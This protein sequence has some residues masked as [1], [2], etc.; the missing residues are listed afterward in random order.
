MN[1]IDGKIAV[2]TGGTQGLGAAIARLFAAAGAAGIAI[3]GRGAEKGKAVAEAITAETG[4]PVM[5]ISADLGNIDDVRRIIASAD[6]RF[7]R[8]DIRSMGHA[9]GLRP[10]PP[11]SDIGTR[12]SP[13]S[14]FPLPQIRRMTRATRSGCETTPTR[15]RPI[16]RSAAMSTS[17]TTMMAVGY[18]RIMVAITID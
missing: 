6:K 2:V 14:L 5:M 13:W 8:V 10:M 16:P 7:G 12:T 17:W 3:V 4:V 11:P 15:L 18:G 1:R 9:T